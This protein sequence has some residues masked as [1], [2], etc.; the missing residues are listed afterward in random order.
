[1]CPNTYILTSCFFLHSSCEVPYFKYSPVLWS[2]HRWSCLWNLGRKHSWSWL[3]WWKSDSEWSEDGE[4]QRYCDKQ[5]RYPLHWW[6]A[7]SWFWSVMCM[8]NFLHWR[9]FL[10]P[11]LDSLKYIVDKHGE[12]KSGKGI[13]F[14]LKY[15]FLFLYL[16]P[17]KSLSLGVPSRLLLQ[18]WWHS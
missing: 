17:S 1:M 7:N 18:T 12:S 11:Y 2:H 16:Q 4:T 9:G 14:V 3:W 5:W 6:S 8:K 10:Q 15:L 13:N